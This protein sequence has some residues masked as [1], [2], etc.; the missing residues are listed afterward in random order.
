MTVLD[1][2][3]RTRMMALG[4]AVLTFAGS[5]VAHAQEPAVPVLAAEARPASLGIE[6]N[7]T[8]R[9]AARRTVDLAFEVAGRLVR[10][11]GREGQ[12]LP[13]GAVLAA[14]D[15]VPF[16]LALDEAR[17]QAG[18]A[19]RSLSRLRSLY[20]RGAGTEAALEEAEAAYELR[21]I[22]E[23][24]A[25]RDLSLATLTAPFD[26]MIARRLVE[27]GSLIQPG[28]AVIRLHDVGEWRVKVSVP[29]S[30]MRLGTSPGGGTDRSSDRPRKRD[31]SC[32]GVPR[33]RSRARPRGAHLRCDLRDRP[34]PGQHALAG[35]DLAGADRT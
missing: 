21:R 23:E 8:G 27:E 5:L 18:L 25:E 12:E 6:R 15:P 9:I 17:V 22:A 14:L 30:L 20:V 10:L 35:H 3:L 33:A 29:E 7:F 2:R 4:F 32:I 24:A 26:A 11:E 28:T 19:E 1:W 34:A 31:A 13:A 16:Q